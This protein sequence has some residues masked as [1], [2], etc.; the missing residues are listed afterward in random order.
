VK[1]FGAR[2]EQVP[3]TAP[4]T[5]RRARR[6]DVP[7]VARALEMSGRGHLERGPWDLMFPDAQER[8]RALE[9]ITGDAPLSW[10]HHSL[11]HV[12]EV[13]GQARAALIAF[14][15]RDF[16]DTSLTAPLLETF[17]LLGWPHERMEAVGPMLAPYLACFPDMP[18]GVWIVENVATAAEY[19][20]HGLVRDLLERALAEG[21]RRACQTAQISCLIGNDAAQRAYERAGFESVEE[22][23]SS[24]FEKLIGVPGF[25]RMTRPLAETA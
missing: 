17:A 8:R 16:G 22:L 10:C 20:R 1:T 21:R 6:S 15:A 23:C 19:R 11:F 9:Y 5:L 3:E 18:P 7:L 25:L 12:A 13:G 14:D 4:A 24:E 2:P